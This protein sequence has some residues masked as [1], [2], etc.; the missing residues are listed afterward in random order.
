MKKSINVNTLIEN[1]FCPEK[2]VHYGKQNRFNIA[3]Q[4]AEKPVVSIDKIISLT[5]DFIKAYGITTYTGNNIVQTA[6]INLDDFN[7]NIKTTFDG[8]TSNADIVWMKFTKDGYVGVIACSNDINFDIPPNSEAY[9]EQKVINGKIS[10]K[11]ATS[12]ILVHSVDKTW[13][14][15]FVLVFP[16]IGLKEGKEGTKQRHDIENGIGNYLI[17]QDIPIIDYFSHRL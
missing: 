9:D 8:L 16:L 12:G 17:S 4:Q 6:E 10:W 5:N 3:K 2:S 11:Y 1:R 14:T 7:K 15:D 13:D